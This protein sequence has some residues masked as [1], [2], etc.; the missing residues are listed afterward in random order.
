MSVMN[1]DSAVTF[2]GLGGRRLHGGF[3]ERLVLAAGRLDPRQFLR[4]LHGRNETKREFAV[5]SDYYLNDIG[6][7]RLVDRRTEDLVTR[8]R[9]GG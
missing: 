2:S 4:Q 5:L 6:A 9:L 1:Q 8:L 7:K 3:M